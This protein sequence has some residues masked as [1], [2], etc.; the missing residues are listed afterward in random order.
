MCVLLFWP[1][2]M[3]LIYVSIGRDVPK[4]NSRKD[5]FA[6]RL[7]KVSSS[8]FPSCCISFPHLSQSV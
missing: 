8:F 6:Q 4:P 5:F 1:V 7:P 2:L 3:N